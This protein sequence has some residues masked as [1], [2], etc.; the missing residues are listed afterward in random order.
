VVILNDATERSCKIHMV[1]M[2]DKDEK[3]HSYRS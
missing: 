3:I 1:V 2:T